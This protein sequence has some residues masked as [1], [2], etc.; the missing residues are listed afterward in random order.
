MKVY[1]LFL[2]MLSIGLLNIGFGQSDDE[3]N[4]Q[5]VYRVSGGQ[6]IYPELDS[7]QNSI[8]TPINEKDDFNMAWY[9]PEETPGVV[10]RF[11][12]L[13]L[14]VQLPAEINARVLEHRSSENGL[15]PYNPEEIDVY[16]E[17]YYQLG[18]KWFGP[19]R[20]NGFYYVDYAREKKYWRKVETDHS[21]R[22]RYAPP[23]VGKYKCI[24]TAIINQKDT[25]VNS[26][27]RF[28]CKASDNKGFVNVGENKR[29]L[30]VGD[31]PFFPVGQNLTGPNTKKLTLEWGDKVA[32]PELYDDFYGLM[33]ELSDSGANYFR[34]IVSPWQS[35]IEFEHLG[36]YGNRMSNAWEFDRLL[37]TAKALDLK[38]HYN[39]A[40][41]YSFEAPSGYA[42]TYWD[43]S[44]K[45][46]PLSPVY[47]EDAACWRD[48]DYG[49]CYRNELD[50]VNPVD[51]LS[52]S[53]AITFYKRRIRYMVARWGFST[54]IGVMELLSE[55][56]NFGEAAI[57]DHNTINGKTG[58]YRVADTADIAFEPYNDKPK[59]TIVDLMAWQIEMCRYIK[60]D[61]GHNQHPIAINYTG[62]P[63]VDNGDDTY[64]SEYVDIASYNSYYLDVEKIEKTYRKVTDY[65]HNEKDKDS[66]LDKP[67]MNS[68][69]GTG[70]GS[71]K[72]DANTGYIRRAALTPFTGTVTAAITWDS[73]LNE[74]GPWGY[75]RPIRELMEGIPLD[76]EN[77][78]VQPP[79]VQENKSVEI[80]HLRKGEWGENSKIVGAIANRTFNYWTQGDTLNCLSSSKRPPN[81]YAKMIDFSAT[82]LDNSSRRFKKMGSRKSY[83]ISWFNALTGE[84]IATTTQSSNS[85]GRLTL[86]FPGILTGNNE[87][88]ILFFQIC[89]SDVS[90][91]P[92]AGSAATPNN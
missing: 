79:M 60:E 51:F 83:K 19:V 64:Y 45:G 78:S 9:A 8:E 87:S 69:F 62:N 6:F 84:F 50:M 34:Y 61:L 81:E 5:P 10:G 28:D 7:L 91:K 42:M 48:H 40:M 92:V 33:K 66:Y 46:D 71:Y 14:G 11:E 24:V 67:I 37:D 75:L 43:W 89:R 17:F 74:F 18:N 86:D 36:Y 31:E 13:E 39:M 82:D 1:C 90:F 30:K 20:T 85:F 15:N 68:E 53:I 25:L 72:C 59:E 56:N 49:Y 32:P 27:F 2:I 22:I 77:W 38:M 3:S 65:Y 76:A 57:L 35:E 12:K 29:Y 63:D 26:E 16:A 54:S 44:A 55:A 80:F 23:V 70:A 41:H 52:D 88:P 21:F 4:K 73:H 58:C 47:P